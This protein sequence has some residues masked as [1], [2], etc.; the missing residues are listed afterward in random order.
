MANTYSIGDLVQITA[1]F[2]D[3]DTGDLIN[4][5]TVTFTVRAPDG[6]QTTPS[7]SNT[8]TGIY[9]AQIDITEAGIW[10]WRATGTGSAQAAGSSYFRVQ[11]NTF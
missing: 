6:T 8:S 7:A 4:P 11:Q 9:Q 10:R 5:T 2:T 3:V 1:T